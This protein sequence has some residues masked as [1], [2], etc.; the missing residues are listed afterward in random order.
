MDSKILGD[1]P[2]LGH[3]HGKT[4]V[5]AIPCKNNGRPGFLDRFAIVAVSPDGEE[6]V[7]ALTGQLHGG[8]W[9]QG[10]YFYGSADQLIDL[11]GRA[12]RKAIALS[13]YGDAQS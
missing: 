12:T 7:A 1:L 3:K 10:Y 2:A 11:I 5:A 6:A 8:G 13:G 4:V 9:D